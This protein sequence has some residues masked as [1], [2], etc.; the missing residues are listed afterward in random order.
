MRSTDRTAILNGV[1]ERGCTREV[2]RWRKGDD[3]RSRVQQNRAINA[4]ETSTISRCL[5]TFVSWTGNVVD[6]QVSDRNLYRNT[7]VSD[8]CVKTCN[9]GR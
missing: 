5:T 4:F 3:S 8:D 9:G 7:F 1:L 6:E 2:S